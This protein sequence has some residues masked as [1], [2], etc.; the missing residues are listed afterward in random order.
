MK[1]YLVVYYSPIEAIKQMS[2]VSPEDHQKVMA[3]WMKWKDA[4]EENVKDF[5]APL[6][7]GNTVD[8][9]ANWSNSNI[10]IFYN[11]LFT[12]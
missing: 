8:T 1:N 7:P 2:N 11:N 6:L 5:G 9:N 12:S 4:H 10:F 3:R